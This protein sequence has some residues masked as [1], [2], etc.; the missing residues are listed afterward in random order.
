VFTARYALSPYIKQIR[1]VFNGLTV[2]CTFFMWHFFDPFSSNAIPHSRDFTIALI[3]THHNRQDSSGRVISPTQRPLPDN[4][5]KRPISMPPTRF[6][7]II[8]ESERPQTYALDHAATGIDVL[9][10]YVTC[11]SSSTCLKDQP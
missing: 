8:P 10:T 2:L 5:H 9:W 7:A 3:W 11:T 6:E 1:F 4:T